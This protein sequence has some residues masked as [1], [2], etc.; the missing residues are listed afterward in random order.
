MP[1]FDTAALLEYTMAEMKQENQ[2]TAGEPAQSPP[3]QRVTE[4]VKDQKKVA[5]GHPDSDARKAKHEERLLKQLRTAK[6]S[7]C[8]QRKRKLFP[9]INSRNAVKD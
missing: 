6:E 1:D 3:V 2:E 5:A 9:R 7:F 8:P 4:K